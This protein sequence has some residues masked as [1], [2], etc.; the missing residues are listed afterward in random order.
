MLIPALKKK[1]EGTSLIV[2]W[3]RLCFQCRG[4]GFE[5]RELRSQMLC[6]A[7]GL[8]KQTNTQN[9]VENW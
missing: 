5:V 1:R 8:K 4:P 9:K 7:A 2:Q 6:G 3:L